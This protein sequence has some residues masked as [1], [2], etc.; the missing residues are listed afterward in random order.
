MKEGLCCHLK[1]VISFCFDHV[2]HSSESLLWVYQV[3]QESVED[4]WEAPVPYNTQH[5]GTTDNHNLCSS[6]NPF[7]SD[8][9]HILLP[10][11]LHP[12]NVVEAGG[13]SSVDTEL[14]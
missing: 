12:E 2:R 5:I 9:S 14:E 7:L 3:G 6:P 4:D 11:D 13:L 10:G 1:V 8:L